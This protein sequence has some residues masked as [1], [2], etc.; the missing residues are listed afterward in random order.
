ME[1]FFTGI[2]D[3]FEKNRRVFFIIFFLSF[4][5]AAWFASRVHFEEDISKVLPKDKKIEKLNQ[6]FQSSKFIDK[7]VI[8][9]SLKDPNQNA[10]PDLLVS[11]AD[12]FVQSIRINLLP[13]ISKIQD[14]VDDQV[15]LNFFRTITDH[16]PVFLNEQDWL[17]MD[18]LLKPETIRHTL[19]YD[20]RTLSSPAGLALKKMISADPTGIGFL[21]FK[22]LQQL[23]YDENFELYDDYIITKDHQHLLLFVTPAYPPNNTGQNAKLLKGI[24]QIRDEMNKSN[25]QKVEASYFGAAAVS[26]GNALQLRKDT[27]FTQGMT[28]LFL[29]AFITLYFK[30]KRAAIVILVPVIF[31]ALFSLAAIYFIKGNISVIALGAGSVVL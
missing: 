1:K 11:Y 9:V 31:G 21:G 15:A 23:Q 12:S 27:I 5:L 6:V 20:Y 17:A 16:L 26:V 18:S 19:E 2:Y 29:I 22:K 7:L 28:L 30:R 8:M 10:D 13:Y 25:D 4:A 3:Y 14:K 24:D